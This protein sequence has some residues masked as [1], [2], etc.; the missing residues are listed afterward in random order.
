MFSGSVNKPVFT[1][2]EVPNVINYKINIVLISAKIK[3]V[4][5]LND[6]F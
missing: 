4:L 1:K 3:N 2:D 5:R 6:Q